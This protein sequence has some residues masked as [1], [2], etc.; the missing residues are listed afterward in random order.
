MAVVFESG[1][2]KAGETPA[3]PGMVPLIGKPGRA[4]N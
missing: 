3:V 1:F 2:M 4:T